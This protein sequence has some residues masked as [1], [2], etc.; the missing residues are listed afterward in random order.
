MFRA[1]VSSNLLLNVCRGL[2]ALNGRTACTAGVQI[3]RSSERAVATVVFPVMV[4]R[5]RL[6]LLWLACLLSARALG[7]VRTNLAASRTAFW[8]SV[9]AM[10]LLFTIGTQ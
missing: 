4:C 9:P 5:E 2:S 3:A 6:L 10:A 7:P 8:H 1:Q